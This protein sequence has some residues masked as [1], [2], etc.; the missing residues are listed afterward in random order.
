MEEF[1]AEEHDQ[2]S[3]ML[4]YDDL[5]VIPIT[6]AV[7]KKEGEMCDVDLDGD[8]RIIQSQYKQEKENEAEERERERERE[9]EGEGEGEGEREG[10]EK[11]EAEDSKDNHDNSKNE[12]KFA[13]QLK[14]KH[15][16]VVGERKP[17][18]FECSSDISPFG[19]KPKVT[20]TLTADN[21]K[22]LSKVED[23]FF[24][25]QK[26][27]TNI[28]EN[29]QSTNLTTC[30]ICHTPSIPGK[31]DPQKAMALGLSKGPKY[32]MLTKG[33]SGNILFFFFKQYQLQYDQLRLMTAEL[34][35]LLI[36]SDLQ[37][38]VRCL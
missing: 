27:T 2:K 22:K 18:K 14:T 37:E 4:Q 12:E 31:F 11:Y 23:S 29:V 36:V 1:S 6:L 20:L 5:S 32:G 38:K 13:H 33:L 26:L 25:K 8:I 3:C 17:K 9:G 28:H 19:K 10:G 24:H 15:N 7:E 34:F 21:L 30:Y 16:G 35:P